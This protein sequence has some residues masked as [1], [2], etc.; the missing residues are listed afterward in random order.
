MSPPLGD[1][2]GFLDHEV[3]R[4]AYALPVERVQLR[5]YIVRLG[6]L[7]RE[8]LRLRYALPVERVQLRL[9]IM[10]FL[11][12]RLVRLRVSRRVEGRSLFTH[13]SSPAFI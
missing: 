2:F 13:L 9:L 4:S 10:G 3:R 12:L 7:D 11:N 8:V 6:F 1:V 5:L